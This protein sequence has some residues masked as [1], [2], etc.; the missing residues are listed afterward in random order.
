MAE[1]AAI[2]AL[3]STALSTVGQI[4]QGNYAR[5]QANRQADAM[6]IQSKQAL[7]EGFQQQSQLR[8][9][10]RMQEGTNIA[11]AGA[12][13]VGVSGFQDVFAD[14]V[15]QGERDL[16][17]IRYNSLVESNNLLGQSRET[18]AYGQQ[19]RKQAVIGGLVTVGMGGYN[20]YNNMGKSGE[21]P[22]AYSDA[23]DTRRYDPTVTQPVSGIY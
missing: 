17:T 5:A 21:I 20:A 8:R 1:V 10:L 6:A 13:G 18:R 7:E 15:D 16:A 3:A 2:A 19:A 14:N 4:Q 22:K 23:M 12:S 11:Q 9:Q